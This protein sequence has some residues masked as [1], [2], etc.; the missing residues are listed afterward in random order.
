MEKEK[1]DCSKQRCQLVGNANEV[2]V[3]VN[4]HRCAA[5]LDTGSM[6]TTVSHHFYEQKLMN[7]CEMKSLDTLLSIESAG[8]DNLP[9]Y[10]LVEVSIT[11]TEDQGKEELVVPVLVVDDTTYNNT[12]PVIIGTNVIS[13]L[14]NVPNSQPWRIAVESMIENEKKAQGCNVYTTGAVTIPANASKIVIAR[15]GIMDRDNA[16]GVV[17]GH[18]FL[19]G[20][21]L[22]PTSLV[23]TGEDHKIRIQVMNFSDKAIVI[24][25]R[26]KIAEWVPGIVVSNRTSATQED[27][28]TEETPDNSSEEHRMQI[29]LLDLPEAELTVDQ[30]TQATGLLERWNSVFAANPTELGAAKG[31]KHNIRLTDE[32]PFRERHHRIPPGRYEEVK[33]HLQDM[34]ACGAIRHSKSSWS[35]NVVLVRKKD[36]T[37]RL[38]IDYRKLN[39]RTVRDAYQL[40]RIDET[41]D[42]MH[43][44]LYFSSL[45]LQ[46][47]YWQVEMH[48]DDK[49]KTAFQVGDLGFYECNRMPFGLTNA[50]A[51]FQRLMEQTLQ[52]LSNVI[53]FIDDIVIF[54][55]TFQEHLDKLEQVFCKL[56]DAGLKLKPKKCKLFQRRVRYLGHIISSEGVETDPEKTE[57]ISKWPIPKT[58]HEL[59]RA[60]GLFGYYR[61]FIK[62]YAQ[63]VQPLYEVLKGHENSRQ[64]NKNTRIGLEEKEIKAFEE[65]KK[66]LTQP[67]ILAF[68]NFDEPFELHTDASQAGLG[69]VLYQKQDGKLRVIAYASRGLRPAERNYSAHRL[70]FLALKWAVTDKLHDYLYGQEFVVLTDNNPLSYVLTTAKLDATGSRWLSELSQYQFSIRYRPG[71]KNVDADTLSRL[72]EKHSS[73]DDIRLEE[74]STDAIQAICRMTVDTGYVEILSMSQNVLDGLDTVLMDEDC[75]TSTREW[76]KK[77]RRDPIINKIILLKEQN[78]KLSDKDK[79]MHPQDMKV[80]SREW[81]K[82]CLRKGVLYR[83]RK[84]Q[85]EQVY[86]LVL[87]EA[88]RNNALEGLHDD[89]GHFGQERTLDLVRTRFYWPRMTEEVITKVKNCERCVRRKMTVPDKAPL[90]SIKTYQPMELVAIDYLTVEPSKGNIENI[91]VITDHFSKFCQAV[92]TRNQTAKTTAQA[93]MKFFLDFGFPNR[94]HS[95]QGRNFESDVIKELCNICGID[96]SRTTPYHP[97]GNGQ[98][99]RFNRTLMDMLGTLSAEQ[100]TNWKEHIHTLVDAYN[101]TKHDTTGYSPFFLMFG[102]H[103]RLPI[104]I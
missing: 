16:C 77:Q 78:K 67:P 21:L 2:N 97:M 41:F 71:K 30:V 90:V 44:S 35:S 82:L 31:T 14:K 56:K 79:K 58:V 26:Q 19:P 65:V 93:L 102:R 74:I 47:G 76:R 99:E 54:S 100:K 28:E 42:K 46:S 33:N 7:E 73:D 38:C 62:D 80:Y 96:K 34:L 52:N 101:A 29:P 84:H 63:L 20:G 89:A 37:L 59:R 3:L 17:Q 60:L 95:D 70:E 11:A 25:R 39:Q 91:L 75:G 45:D 8:G 23:D 13:A 104:D 55:A 88:D 36:G 98:C 57:V 49:P 4:G 86:Q 69:A 83:M 24:Q 51:T 94:L 5:L 1:E 53:V 6:V 18:E 22:I 103:A 87:P 61:R 15:L 68:A 12:I 72:P 10:G 66:K 9:Y 85:E 48:E 43:G 50:P 32:T 81:D 40:P 92:P 64:A 27:E